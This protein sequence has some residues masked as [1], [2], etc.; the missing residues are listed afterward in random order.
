ME[1]LRAQLS[2]DAKRERE[3]AEAALAQ[4][5]ASGLE[6]RD[7]LVAEQL[8]HTRSL[9]EDFQR[10]QSA[11]QGQLADACEKLSALQLLY[12]QR[13]PRDE[14]THARAPTLD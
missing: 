1:A 11:V 12:E 3:A 9:T 2:A 7:T 13:P 6:A 4:E 14:G 10:A 5:R 8:Q